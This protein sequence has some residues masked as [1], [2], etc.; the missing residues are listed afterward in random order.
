MLGEC[1]EHHTSPTEHGFWTWLGQ[2]WTALARLIF[3]LYV[4]DAVLDPLVVQDCEDSMRSIRAASLSNM[5][6]V[7]SSHESILTG[8]P[9][10]PLI[11]T[12]SRE[13]DTCNNASRHTVPRRPDIPRLNALYGEILRFMEQLLPRLPGDSS[14]RTGS[15]PLRDVVLQSSLGSFMQRLESSYADFG[16]LTQTL[17]WGVGCLRLGVSLSFAGDN[18]NA[19]SE[20][21]TVA[22]S[23]VR[24]PSISSAENWNSIPTS[25]ADVDHILHHIASIA[26]QAEIDGYIS[27][28]SNDLH[29]WFSR[30]VT[31][32]LRDNAREQREREEASSIYK[33]SKLDHSV[34]DGS[35]TE[36]EEIQYL[37][38]QYAG[39]AGEVSTAPATVAHPAT[40]ARAVSQDHMKD[41]IRFHFQLF[42]PEGYGNQERS[43]YTDRRRNVLTHFLATTTLGPSSASLDATSHSWRVSLYRDLLTRFQTQKVNSS[44]FYHDPNP[45]EIRRAI[46]V[47]RGLQLRIESILREWPDQMVLQHLIDHCQNILDYPLRSPVAR[48]LAALERLL[49]RTDDWEGY[50]SRDNSLKLQQNELIALIIEWRRLELRGWSQLLDSE[51]AAFND[52]ASEWWFRLYEMLVIGTLSSAATDETNGSGAAEEH[53]AHCVPLIDDYMMASPLGQFQARLDL[54][55]SFS[56]FLDLLV[57]Q[58][59][60]LTSAALKHASRLAHSQADHYG[61]LLPDVQAELSRGKEPIQKE[62]LD[63]IKLAS[64]KDVNVYALKQSAEKTHRHL[65]RCIRKYR[66]SLRRPVTVIGVSPFQPLREPPPIPNKDLTRPIWKSTPSSVDSLH[67]LSDSPHHL[68]NLAHTHSR[69]QRLLQEQMKLYNPDMYTS[70]VEGLSSHIIETIQ[71]LSSTTIP[72]G[73]RE[74]RQKSINSMVS[75]KRRAI[76]DLMK[77]LRRLGLPQN[78][79]PD[80]LARQHSRERLFEFAI[81]HS[82]SDSTLLS[83]TRRSSRYYHSLIDGLQAV[84]DTV[85]S[86]HP[87]FTTRDIQRLL[88]LTESSFS[89]G[90][91]AQEK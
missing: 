42:H 64:W 4:P 39:D 13:R 58:D 43:W 20:A 59:T 29:H 24:F 50:A 23:L 74:Q 60:S 8:N 79:R 3:E 84:R 68:K 6:A 30:V 25:D 75:Q 31:L 11:E 32:W 33:T 71:A 38:P 22:Y 14:I 18:S 91:A 21:S 77:E 37:F 66:E 48:V 87:D 89:F 2:A 70:T 27:D 1:P 86:H 81:Q 45:G 90:L 9:S 5:I 61:Y 49:V 65:H 10:N 26:Y 35:Q 57:S 69:F 52:G 55:R 51:A 80:I 56:I 63:Y 72:A 83:S 34:P 17:L 41:V 46:P 28:R 82:C 44:N 88:S 53:T 19:S 67:D 62:I 16:D 73:S 54:L 36:D 12:L 7:L 78:P 76:V 15:Q 85:G 40:R 47:L